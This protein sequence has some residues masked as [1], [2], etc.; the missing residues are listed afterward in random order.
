MEVLKMI[1]FSK[2]FIKLMGMLE[3]AGIPHSVVW[4]TDNGMKIVFPDGS[5]VALNP[6]TSGHQEGLLEGFNGK[7]RHGDYD[8]MG[9]LTAEEVFKI[10][11]K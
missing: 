1:D 7:F 11:T 8:V 2:N 3:E 5:D 10:I 6:Y 4:C 9:Y